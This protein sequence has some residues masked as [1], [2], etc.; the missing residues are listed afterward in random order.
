MKLLQKS[1]F[2]DVTF[3]VGEERKVFS[4][5]S[6]FLASLSS[7][8]DAMLFG[9]K[10]QPNSEIELPDISAAAFRTVLDLSQCNN[11]QPPKLSPETIF[12]VKV[13]VDK[14]QITSLVQWLDSSFSSFADGFKSVSDADSEL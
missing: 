5:N 1:R 2:C 14:Y 9:P 4:T 12:D 3:L 10:W 6:I 13:M 8:F 7:V 11:A